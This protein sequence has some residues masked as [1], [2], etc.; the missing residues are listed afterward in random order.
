M[1]ISGTFPA[2]AS[3]AT[4]TFMVYANTFGNINQSL[5]R[6]YAITVNPFPAISGNLPA[7]TATTAYSGS[8]SV[9][10]G[11]APFTYS[12]LAGSLPA[13]LVLNPSS[14]QI[15]GTPASAGTST[16]TARVIDANG[17]ASSNTFSIAVQA[18]PFAVNPAPPPDGA[19]GQFYNFG[20]SATGG[21]A[22]YTWSLTSGTLPAGLS[23]RQDGV[24]SGTPTTAGTSSFLV[25]ATDVTGQRALRQ[26]SIT[27]V[28]GNVT[29][30]TDSLP[31]GIVGSAYSAAVAATGGTAPYTFSISGGSLP[32][33]VTLSSGGSLSGTPATPGS[34]SFTVTVRDSA[35]RTAT[36]SYSVTIAAP[37]QITTA[38]LPAA[39]LGVAYTA[40][41]AATGGAPAY[42]YALA[43]G[44][45]P[46]GLQ[47]SAAGVISGTPAAAG[48]FNF[49]VRVTDTAQGSAQRSYTLT[50]QTRPV[51]TTES[52]PSGTAGS[53]YSATLAATGTQ[54][55]AWT[56][57]AGTLPPGLSLAAGS[58]EISGTPTAAGTF[59]F[60]AM[61]SDGNTP[62]LTASRDYSI[63]IDRPAL[64]VLTIAPSGNTATP[65]TQPAFTMTLSQ[66]YPLPLSG[67]ARLTFA[68]DGAAPT[69]PDVRFSTGGTSV[70]FT[71][72]AG[73]TNAVPDS[74]SQFAFQTGTTAG[75]IT[76]TVSV[77]QGTSV[78]Q[79]DPYLTR[80]VR[81]DR[82]AP[83]ISSV[84][85]NRTASGFEVIIM[86]FSNTREISGSTFRFTAASGSSL[87]T[88]D[89]TVA[90][91]PVFQTWFAS[92]PSQS[93]GGQFL[94]TVPFNVSG[95]TSSLSAV[96]VTITNAVGSASGSANF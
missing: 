91:Q 16:F 77:R 61:I 86:G 56:A 71:I 75:T 13:G 53:A 47:L 19:V 28:P 50:V 83:T 59:R 80:T 92:T 93:F 36:R 20:M 72:P 84:R 94:L 46:G 23:L 49:T 55:L 74:G 66:P 60:T 30:T 88:S 41:L 65:G 11:T 54:P 81:V 26:F 42:T 25:A 33:G 73:Q 22:P 48:A 76:M 7:G 27:I 10:G 14:G 95:S 2:V 24:L 5:T 6:T 62:A 45:L 29:I 37:L 43:T 18:P 67:T 35:N 17:A 4:Y 15:S 79:P 70:D 44:A 32:P 87:S 34:Y 85:I 31:N 3:P 38:S 64:P 68:P 82:A 90:V 69:D 96:Q 52:L 58:G 89:F 40:N 21:A 8:I 63:Q 39:T 9:S 78:M 1:S 12:L 51:I 57:S